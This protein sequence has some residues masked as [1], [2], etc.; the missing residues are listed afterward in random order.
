MTVC[1]DQSD[2]APSSDSR[3]VFDV[4]DVLA[5]ELIARAAP[6]R[7]PTAIVLQHD[8]AD[9]SR[10][11]TAKLPL[12]ALDQR[13]REPDSP[14]PRIDRESRHAGA[15]AVPAGHDCSDQPTVIPR[16]HKQPPVA[17]QSAAHRRG[18]VLEAVGGAELVPEPD[19][20]R[21]VLDPAGTKAD[22][23]Q[24][25]GVILGFRFSHSAS[26]LSVVTVAT[27]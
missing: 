22:A 20:L 23:R 24:S 27:E 6:E 2:A 9:P 14:I 8:R 7:A 21:N 10:T 4:A 3:K 19:H 18:L 25:R 16:K 15:P 5:I 1:Y 26:H 17:F 11:E 13:P 12:N